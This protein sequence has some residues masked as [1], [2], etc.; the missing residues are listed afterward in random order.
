MTASPERIAEIRRRVADPA[1]EPMRRIARMANEILNI[2]VDHHQGELEAALIAR[3]Y[4]MGDINADLPSALCF[5]DEF[6]RSG[7]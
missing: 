1:L 5:I 6:G 7:K 4:S 3:G 2:L